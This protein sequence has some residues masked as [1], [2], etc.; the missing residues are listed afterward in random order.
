C[1]PSNRH[2]RGGMAE[3][4]GALPRLTLLGAGAQRTREP[5][6][7]PFQGRQPPSGR[8]ALKRTLRPLLY[9]TLAAL[10][11]L[12]APTALARPTAQEATTQAP[13][14]AAQAAPPTVEMA[15]HG[16]VVPPAE[17]SAQPAAAPIPRSSP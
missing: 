10:I 1:Y 14:E 15:P 13:D 9:A 16:D 2:W 6:L 17:D 3:R 7:T 4:S 8:C 5:E 11:A 12:S